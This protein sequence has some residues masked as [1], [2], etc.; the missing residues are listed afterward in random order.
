MRDSIRT[1]VVFLAG[2]FGTTAQQPVAPTPDMAGSTRGETWGDYNVVDS[3]ET[4]YRFALTGGNLAQYRSSVN[5]GNGIRLLNSY[6]SL[7]SKDGHGRYFDRIT[8]TTL[9]LGNDP[10]QSASVRIAKNRIYRYDMTWRLNNYFNPGLTTDGAAGQHF[11]NTQYKMQDHDLVLFPDS[12]LKFFLGYSGSEQTGP[13]F[14][15]VQLFDARGDISPLFSDLRRL[16][17]EYRLGNEFRLFG[18]RVNWMHGWENFKEDTQTTLATTGVP[19]IVAPATSLTSFQRL[20]PYHGN[21][22]YWQVALFSEHKY[23]SVNGRFTYTAGE[24]GFVL[25]ESAMGPGRFGAAQNRQIVTYGNGQRPV[26]TGNLNVTVLAT[27]KLTVTNST[28]VY[29]VRTSGN[30]YFAQFDNSTQSAE[31]LYFNYLGIRTIANDTDLNYQFSPLFGAFGDYEYSNRRISSV[32][33]FSVLGTP[34]TTPAQQTNQLHTG[35]IGLRLRPLKPLS[36]LLSAEL[37]RADRP[38]TP[39]ED[40]NYHALNGRVQY[41]KKSLLLSG[42]AESNYSFNSVT[43][44][45]YSSQARKYFASGAWTPNEW[46]SFDSSFSR[47]HLYTIGG[48]AYFAN[49]DPVFGETSIYLSNINTFVGGVRFAIHDRADVYLGYTHVQ[50][51]GDGRSTPEGSGTG[52]ALP[53]FQIAQTFPVA[54]RSPMARVSV[55]INNKLRW[56]AGYQYYGFRENFFADQNFRAN[57]GYTSLSWSF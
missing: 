8:I 12:N 18:V 48:I 29:N 53:A 27:S 31:I 37:G 56:N 42:G 43:L 1:I 33:Q 14:T 40:R 9:G 16:R 15:S 49:L 32:E 51:V 35:R 36:V 30:S 28:S 25:D 54:F 17:H 24:R 46:L 55:R 45:S 23:V 11:L 41:R 50:D 52:S 34:S 57:T 4:G 39:T 26:A 47:S 13:A 3:V 19:G 20:E 7:N 21:S 5:Y 2:A 10:Y 6:F 38:F 22:P 44:S